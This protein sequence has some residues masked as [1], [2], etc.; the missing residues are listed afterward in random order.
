[1]IIDFNDS[2]V[3][4]KHGMNDNI[5]QSKN[6][7]VIPFLEI[8]DVYIPIYALDI[9]IQKSESRKPYIYMFSLRTSGKMFKLYTTTL[10]ERLMWFTCF[11]CIIKSN[12]N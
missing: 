11:D 10:N 6:V 12:Q 8:E 2:L 4:I 7:H 9:Q 5:N 1:M 3:Y